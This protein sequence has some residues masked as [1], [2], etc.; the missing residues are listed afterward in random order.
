[1]LNV[2]KAVIVWS[3]LTFSFS[4]CASDYEYF[5]EDLLEKVGVNEFYNDVERVKRYKSVAYANESNYRVK[6]F[7][8]FWVLWKK[9][10]VKKYRRELKEKIVVNFELEEIKLIGELFQKGFYA[11]A[12]KDFL[13]DEDYFILYN[14]LLLENQFALFLLE[15]RR[16]ILDEIYEQFGLVISEQNLFY[17]LNSLEQLG[18]SGIEIQPFLSDKRYFVP[19]DNVA[20]YKHH[21]KR[22][23]YH[24]LG[25]RLYRYS[26][27]ELMVFLKR[28]RKPLY[29]RFTQLLIN[30]HY[31]FLTD[32][33][34]QHEQ[35]LELITVGKES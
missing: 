21:S 14:N 5:V 13:A 10:D 32:F 15:Q 22:L 19:Q 4:I 31:L 29:R 25:I 28:T 6:R 17:H 9:F 16:Q 12:L 3:S 20:L 1:M 27:H 24:L 30:F 33:I 34:A 11:K 23:I 35:E 2:L 8:R 7:S 18:A 26:D